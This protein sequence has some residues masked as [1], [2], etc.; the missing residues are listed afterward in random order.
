[1]N[2]FCPRSP[3]GL[4]EACQVRSR[5]R[6]TTSQKDIDDGSFDCYYAKIIPKRIIP[7]LDLE[8][9]QAGQLVAANGPVSEC[10]FGAFSLYFRK[11]SQSIA[12]DCRVLCIDG[13]LR[14]AI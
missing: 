9:S 7:H 8:S 5:F 13:M 3:R 12:G 14:V 10:P 6:P 2:E 11:K 1:M 4:I